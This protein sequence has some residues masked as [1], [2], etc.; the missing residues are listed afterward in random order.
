M[1]VSWI[2]LRVLPPHSP[3]QLGVSPSRPRRP[4]CTPRAASGRPCGVTRSPVYPS[5]GKRT[6]MK[7]LFAIF[8]LLGFVH[9]TGGYSIAD[10]VQIRH[11]RFSPTNDKLVFNYCRK[12]VPCTI[13]LYDLTTGS[14]SYYQAPQNEI[15]S[16][17]NFSPDG[18]KLAFI[19]IPIID[20]K[21]DLTGQVAIMNRDGSGVLKLTNSPTFKA[22]PSFSL[23]GKRIIYA[24]ANKRREEGAKTPVSAYDVYE[25][26]SNAGSERRLTNLEL[27]EMSAPFYFPD[28]KRFIFAS[29]GDA[30]PRKTFDEH[31][32]C[33]K[34]YKEQYQLNSIFITVE[35]G[36]T[37]RPA[38]VNGEFSNEPHISNDGS[39]IVFVSITNKM[40]GV[41]GLYNYDIFLRKD[42]VNHRLTRLGTFLYGIAL[43]PDGTRVAF[44]SDKERKK[45]PTLWVM[46]SDGTGLTEIKLPKE[47]KPIN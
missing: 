4:G 39:K 10:E 13:G 1:T 21:R 22:S 27:Y 46:R 31:K 41:H 33:K 11:P 2:L 29:Y 38:F 19:I 8:C 20:N 18:T 23:D 44:L 40:D 45:K 17:A 24:R 30:C 28:G 25:V 42:G 32:L 15:W 7:K 43:S 36:D 35:G 47:S 5:S 16:D 6:V 26:D 12:T 34:Q 3:A 14:L 9:F 37:S